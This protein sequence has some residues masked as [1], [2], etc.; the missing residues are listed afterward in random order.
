[1][2]VTPPPIPNAVSDSVAQRNASAPAGDAALEAARDRLIEHALRLAPH[3]GVHATA[4]ASLQVLRVDR[5][6]PLRGAIYEPGVVL[7]LQ[8]RKQAM[9]GIERL[10]YDPLHYLLASTTMPTRGQ[11][12]EATPQRPYLCLRLRVDPRELAALVLEAAPASP[13]ATGPDDRLSSGLRVARVSPPLIDA[14]ARLVQLLDQPR[15]LP[16]LAPLAQ[17]EVFYRVL[18]GSLGAGLRALAVA[19]S[20]AQ[21]IQR[22]IDLLRRRF[23]EPLRVDDLAAAAH[24]SASSLHLRFKQLTSM[25]PLQYQKQLRLHHARELMLGE[26]LD[27]ASAAHRVG[28]ESASQFSR[29]YRRMF[30]APPR[31]EVQRA[32][33]AVLQG[34]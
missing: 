4:I 12:I 16:V 27:A 22:A 6:M 14:M 10:V 19:D 17:R 33:E 7:V 18:T 3:E 5:P 25:A 31:A 11:V 1:M 30:G 29:E 8:G 26:G 24:M 9:L 34:V 13:P 15:D 32:R 2:S 23:D 21:R 28:Y 20:H